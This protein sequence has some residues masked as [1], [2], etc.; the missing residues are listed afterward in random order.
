MGGSDWM[1]D[2]EDIV[3]LRSSGTLLATSGAGMLT[4]ATSQFMLLEDGKEDLHGPS[5]SHGFRGEGIL[6][7]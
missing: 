6:D 2:E 3:E 1:V 5:R 7:V 4:A